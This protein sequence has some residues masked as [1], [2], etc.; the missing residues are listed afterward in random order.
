[1]TVMVIM[2]CMGEAAME[3]T[4]TQKHMGAAHHMGVIHPLAHHMEAVH[5]M[6]AA[7]IMEVAAMEVVAHRVE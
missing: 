4:V 7:Q 1:M 6:G 2:A 5:H 3:D